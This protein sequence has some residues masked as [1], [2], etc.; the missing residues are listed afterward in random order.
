MP[1]AR[2]R[3]KVTNAARGSTRATVNA[4]RMLPRNKP[5]NTMT[6]TVASS[7]ADETAPTALL[8]SDARS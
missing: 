5:S 3:M 8:T 2:M 6:R 4:A 1:K 7:N